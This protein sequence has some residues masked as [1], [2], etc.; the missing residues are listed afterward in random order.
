MTL[1][2]PSGIVQ[3][4]I[5]KIADFAILVNGTLPCRHMQRI[6]WRNLR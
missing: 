2:M 5:T 6:Q 1:Q 4:K 3:Q